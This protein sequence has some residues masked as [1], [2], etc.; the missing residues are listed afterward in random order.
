VDGELEF[1]VLGALEAVR[2]GVRVAVP[3]R[4]QRALL[5]RL[6]LAEGQVVSADDLVDAVWEEGS[7]ERARH[8]LH[9]T[10]SRLRSRLGPDVLVTRPPGYLLDVRRDAVDAFRFEAGFRQAEGLLDGAA[11]AALKILDEVLGLWRGPAY[12]EFAGTFAQGSSVRL[13]ELRLAARECQCEALLEL[14]LVDRALAELTELTAAHPLRERPHGLLMRASYLAGRPSEALEV[15]RSLRERLLDELGLE[16][17]PELDR[18]QGTLLRRELP[19]P[20]PQRPM[21][22][23]PVPA[24]TTLVGRAAELAELR[25]LVTME[26]IVTLVGPGGVG[27]TRLA[28]E[29]AVA[30]TSC[31]VDLAAVGDPADVPLAFAD[32]LGLPEPAVGSVTDLLVDALRAQRLLLVADN[33]EHIVDAAAELVD[34]VARHCPGVVVLATSRE[35]LAVEGERVVTVPPLGVE[36]VALFGARLRASGGPDLLDADVPLA[37]ELCARLDGLPLA[38]ELAAARARSLGLATVAD[39]PALDVLSGG[40][41]TAQARHRSLRAVLD[42]S[43]ALLDSAER[44]LL[45]RLAVF[46][47][48]FRLSDAE[49]VC[50]DGLLPAARIADALAGL[51]DKSMVAGPSGDRYR[52]LDTVRA[53]GAG[54]LAE[55][56]ENLRT[57]AAHARHQIGR[58]LRMPFAEIGDAHLGDL[59]AALR[60]ACAH[61]AD[62]AVRLSAALAPFARYHLRFDFQEWAERAAGLPGAAGHPLLAVAWGSAAS[63]AW[64]RGEFDRARELAE[65]GIAAAPPDDPSAADPLM[66][67]GDIGGLESRFDDSVAF[68]E[69]A[70]RVLGPGDVPSRCEALCG[71]AIGLSYR[72][73]AGEALAAA[74]ECLA[75]ADRIGSPVLRAL[76]KYTMGEVRLDRDPQAALA[77]LDDCRR[78]AASARALLI[79]GLG[80][81]SSVTLRGRLS[82]DPAAALHAYR[83]VIEHWRRIGNHTQQWITLRNLIPVLVRAEAFE[84]ACI[85]Y[86]ALASSPVRFPAAADPEA[87]ALAEAMALAENG[88]GLGAAAARARGVSLPLDGLAALA[89]TAIDTVPGVLASEDTG[90][91]G[92]QDG[93][94]R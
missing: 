60:W 35:L 86:G 64:A 59:R 84:P 18:L 7:L 34:R 80:I 26:R 47:G 39:R 49:A 52:L 14:G 3:S 82:D 11:A 85:L 43:F 27:K 56:G 12:A 89:L 67:L 42:W 58:V 54:L 57:A 13:A 8:A 63:G 94:S 25:T 87:V 2:G 19:V 91:P 24:L 88:L 74:A 29:V 10:V 46:A 73:D 78:L 93:S 38:I 83:E 31:W 23:A 16:P 45:R 1:R 77:H 15:Y 22:G 44:V 40:R 32:A 76:A 9:T 79:E 65:R 92:R 48:E 33:C 81:V 36:A 72:G 71:Q 70:L 30:D 21:G 68:A 61:D 17:S 69:E 66:V 55:H 50:A 41:R 53:Y 90:N 75:V 20:T 6:L 28:R 4:A 37:E 51:A 5:A 62:L